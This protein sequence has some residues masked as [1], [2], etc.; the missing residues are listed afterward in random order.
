MTYSSGGLIQAADYNNFINGSNQFNTVWST[1]TGNAGYG[2]TAISAVSAGNQVTAAQWASLINNLNNALTHQSGSGSGISATTS[3]SKIN[4]LSTLSTNINTAYTNRLNAYSR[5][6]KTTGTE[7][8]D[9]YQ[10]PSSASAQSITLNR[11]ITFASGDA[12]R[13]FFN[14]GGRLNL[15]ITDVVNQDGSGRS[16]DV[17][18]L[19]KTNLAGISNFG[20]YANG[21]IQGT[22]GTIVTNNT[23]FGYWNS[24]TTATTIARI[25]STTYPYNSDYVYVQISTSAAN[26]SGHGDNGLQIAVTIYI[27]LAALQSDFGN[28]TVY[29]NIKQRIDIE[30][31]ETSYL[32]NSWGTITIS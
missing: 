30:P 31:P 24:S 14:A 25:T 27:Y 15:V 32:S 23:S 12:A 6:I 19:V 13:Y 9:S 1:G 16:A 28:K 26:N 17:V 22:G 4:Y 8:Q 29:V 5:G 11:Y 21:G 18:R 2:Q 7:Y 3:G 10:I 20:G